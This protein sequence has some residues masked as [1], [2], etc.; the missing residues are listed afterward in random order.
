VPVPVWAWVAALL[1]IGLAS[2]FGLGIYDEGSLLV[3]ARSV[4]HG[5]VPSRDFWTAYPPGMF[6]LVGLAFR[7]FG[8]QIIVNRLLHDA[9]ALGVC[10]AGYH[11]IATL[12]GRGR[13]PLV[14]FLSLA[15]Y[16]GAFRTP[17][18]YPAVLC[19]LLGFW[20]L[21]ELFGNGGAHSRRRLR[22]AGLAAGLCAILRYDIA[23]YLV[24]AS[25]GGGLML[26]VPP[27]GQ[28]GR[29]R[30]V[31]RAAIDYLSG[32]LGP[33]LL[34]YGVLIALAGIGPVYAQLV[35]FPLRVFPRVR[36]LP[37]DR[38]FTF[39][40]TAPRTSWEATWFLIEFR[41]LLIYVGLVTAGVGAAFALI[42]TRRAVAP[43]LLAVSLLALAFFNQFRVRSDATHGWPLVVTA[44]VVGTALLGWAIASQHRSVRVAGW[45]S[46]V[47]WAVVLVPG[48]VHLGWSRLHARYL[49]PTAAVDSPA[50]AGIRIAASEGTN[51]LLADLRT[52]A[53][54][55][56]FI[57]SGAV[58]HDQV[59]LNDALIYFLAGRQSPTPYPDLVP[60]V[61]D[62][63]PVQRDIVQALEA[64]NVRTIVLF[65]YVSSE[66]NDSSRNTH[67]DIL[68]R[69]L[70]EK[71]RQVAQYQPYYRV[72]RRIEP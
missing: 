66:P 71:F 15:L 10:V 13:W 42:R 8:E 9:I 50:A 72:L 14:G 56:R 22:R 70:R 60:G 53:A 37:L 57:F 1:W 51:A 32:F 44:L 27:A 23:L 59:V 36:A 55:E 41:R 49:E 64:L 29:R 39:L 58:D 69:M 17:Y 35:E 24:A 40:F 43:L 68:D 12:V 52:R 3:G 48:M 25:V 46:A 20:S 62:T 67:V 28:A 31:L 6:W 19:L 54:G 26:I 2:D 4:A 30:E 16:V 5:G 65:D 47:A 7:V 61:I 38:P 45:I 63:E 11:L 21:L 34:A 33:V 18:G